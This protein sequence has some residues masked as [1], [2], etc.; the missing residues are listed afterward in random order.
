[1][2][3]AVGG[4]DRHGFQLGGWLASQETQGMDA[5]FQSITDRLGPD[6]RTDPAPSPIPARRNLPIEAA[7]IVDL[8]EERVRL[9]G[10]GSPPNQPTSRRVRYQC[11][12]DPYEH[13]SVVP[14]RTQTAVRLVWISFP[15]RCRRWPIQ[16]KA[17]LSRPVGWHRGSPI[18]SA[19]GYALIAYSRRLAGRHG[20]DC[21]G[22]F[23]KMT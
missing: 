17:R 3:A 13:P 6:A 1:M 19:K 20:V 4:D 10:H 22:G 12:G 15:V 11:S 14:F 7:M 23:R 8:D 2:L 5:R 18:R 16:A 9:R 21:P